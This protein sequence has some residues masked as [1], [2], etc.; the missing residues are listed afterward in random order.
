MERS[1]LRWFGHV[2]VMSQERLARQVLLVIQPRESGPEVVQGP[3]SRT[4]RDCCWPWSIRDLL[5]MLPPPRSF[6]E[7]KWKRK[8]EITVRL[9]LVD[10]T[11]KRYAWKPLP[12]LESLISHK[13]ETWKLPTVV[14]IVIFNTWNRC[15]CHF[16][17][18]L[19]CHCG[20]CAVQ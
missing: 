3:D 15:V 4:I 12:G 8:V 14:C 18:Y 5:E 10:V 2:P 9:S 11:L 17:T 13:S 1:Q 19:C 20:Q 16:E 7:K 6:P